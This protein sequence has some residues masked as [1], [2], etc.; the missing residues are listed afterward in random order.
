MAPKGRGGGS[1]T[2]NQESIAKIKSDMALKKCAAA[3]SLLKYK[4]SLVL[5]NN[6]KGSK[7]LVI[8][9]TQHDAGVTLSGVS[10][11][12]IE[13][14]INGTAGSDVQQIK[15]LRDG[16]ILVQTINV[17]QAQK[18]IK[19]VGLPNSVDVIVSEHERLNSS[20]G[21]IMCKTIVTVLKRKY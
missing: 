6:T 2:A 14:A 16:S 21:V 13:K 9:N 17:Y 3:V 7:F 5:K 10:T 1:P 11:F 12:L 8:K 20:K 15:L 4:Q 18:L 19:L